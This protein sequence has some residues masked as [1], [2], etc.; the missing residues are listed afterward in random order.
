MPPKLANSSRGAVECHD[1]D[2]SHRS[3]AVA[4]V[5]RTH[6][7]SPRLGKTARQCTVAGFRALRRVV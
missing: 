4:S 5:S 2:A 6:E 1:P 7:G 3:A